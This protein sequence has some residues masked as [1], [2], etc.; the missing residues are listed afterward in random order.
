MRNYEGKFPL[1]FHPG[2]AD[3]PWKRFF[4]GYFSFHN[5][6]A[7]KNGNFPLLN[8]RMASAASLSPFFLKADPGKIPIFT[9]SFLLFHSCLEK[10]REKK[11]RFIP[12]PRWE[13]S[14]S[15]SW[16]PALFPLFSLFSPQRCSCP[17]FKE[18]SH[19][20]PF[21]LAFYSQFFL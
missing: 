11:I 2:L 7:E 4:N 15:S 17:G 20:F 16:F 1:F 14:N 12:N 13:K 10:K 21:I 9:I 3:S 8:P 19:S 18:F 5:N 6:R